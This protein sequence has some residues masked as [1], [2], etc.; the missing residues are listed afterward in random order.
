M[1]HLP[2]GSKA[3]LASVIDLFKY[4]LSYNDV[5]ILHMDYLTSVF[6]LSIWAVHPTAE[7]LESSA[8][9][10]KLCK[11]LLETLIYKYEELIGVR[12]RLIRCIK[13]LI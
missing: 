1:R 13:D 9:W 12:N 8:E 5:N 7:T 11:R 4:L 10:Q 6:G 3:F 2:V